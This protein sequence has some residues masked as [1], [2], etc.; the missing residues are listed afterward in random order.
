MVTAKSPKVEGPKLEENTL[1]EK[2]G[3]AIAELSQRNSDNNAE[4]VMQK[5]GVTVKDPSALVS[6]THDQIRTEVVAGTYKQDRHLE[7][8]ELERLD[9]QKTMQH[10]LGLVSAPATDELMAT[11]KARAENL[12]SQSRDKSNDKVQ[13]SVPANYRV[14]MLDNDGNIEAVNVVTGRTYTGPASELTKDI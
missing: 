12:K 9:H 5:T 7:T 14:K 8:L 13:N 1:D 6:E 11:A 3:A 4:I 2:T 10:A